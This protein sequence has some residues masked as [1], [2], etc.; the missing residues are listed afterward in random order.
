VPIDHGSERKNGGA[1]QRV[2][3]ADGSIELAVAPLEHMAGRCPV[4]WLPNTRCSDDPFGEPDCPPSTL[5]LVDQ[6]DTLWSMLVRGTRAN[7]DPTLVI[8][9]KLMERRWQER[10][11]KGYGQKIEVSEVGSA[12][13]LEMTGKTI[14]TGWLTAGNIRTAIERRT[15]IVVVEPDQAGAFATSGVALQLLRGTANNRAAA[16]RPTLGRTIV[17]LGLIALEMARGHGIKAIDSRAPGPGIVLPPREVPGTDGA[18]STY[19]EHT[20]GPGRWIA[21][22]WGDLY[23]ATPQDLLVTAQ[24]LTLSTGGQPVL[25]RETAVGLMVNVAQTDTD[26]ATELERIEAEAASKVASFESSMTPDADAELDTL[27]Q[28]PIA[29]A[30]VAATTVQETALN[31]AQTKSF[32]DTIGAIGVT[33]APGAGKFII[34]KS[35]PTAVDDEAELDA[36]I[37]DQIA[38]A[39]AKGQTMPPEPMQPRGPAPGQD[40]DEDESEER[41]QESEV[42]DED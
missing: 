8:S 42:L 9:D 16:R 12:S 4:V 5:E 33:L 40:E 24:A 18:E 6:L 21:I 35:F 14:E 39:E 28:E 27:T 41:A 19:T 26:V 10:R 37:A 23:P 17:Q 38:F 13:L 22:S 3:A 1:S 32:A 29:T 34:K 2:A 30:T 36:A 7:L 25:S 15:G 11:A 20:V 31:G